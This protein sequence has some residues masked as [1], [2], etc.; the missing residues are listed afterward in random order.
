MSLAWPLLGLPKV[1]STPSQLPASGPPFR[2]RFR[3][4][5][6]V[7]LASPGDDPGRAAELNAPGQR[8]PR[9]RSPA[10]ARPDNLDRPLD[11]VRVAPRAFP[12]N[13]VVTQ[14]H[15]PSADDDEDRAAPKPGGTAVRRGPLGSAD[16]RRLFSGSGCPGGR[17]AFVA[18]PQPAVLLS[19]RRSTTGFNRAAGKPGGKSNEGAGA[20]G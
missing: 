2:P 11:L 10:S 18:N 16:P 4:P 12:S 5:R 15:A 17:P 13:C 6:S 3:E 8:N 19:R 14:A 7:S 9:T 1:D 20:M